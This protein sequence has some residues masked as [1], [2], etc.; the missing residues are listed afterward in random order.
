M[1]EHVTAIFSALGADIA[2]SPQLTSHLINITRR[3]LDTAVPHCVFPKRVAPNERSSY[4]FAHLTPFKQTREHKPPEPGIY[5]TSAGVYTGFA[6]WN[7][8]AWT[9]FF[10]DFAARFETRTIQ[11]HASDTVFWSALSV[12]LPATPPVQ[13]V[14]VIHA[15]PTASN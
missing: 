9:S 12:P 6:Q 10:Y 11:W 14:K 2:K 3:L 15:K 4:L 7:G 13:R 1:T 8:T 5:L